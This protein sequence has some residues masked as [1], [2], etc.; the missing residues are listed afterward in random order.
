MNKTK[1]EMNGRVARYLS[2]VLDFLFLCPGQF[3]D[4]IN[5]E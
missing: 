3:Q 4:K 2:N 5:V 1:R